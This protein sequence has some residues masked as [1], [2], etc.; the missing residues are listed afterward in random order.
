MQP[1][2]NLVSEFQR[3]HGAPPQKIARAP[4][5]VNLIGEHTDYNE[6]FVMPIA[7]DRD[8][9]IAARARDDNKICI[10][11]L[12]VGGGQ[13]DVFALDDIPHHPDYRWANY[14]RGVAYYLA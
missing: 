4:G 14:V 1:I 7:I 11:A 12:D 8:V 5:R 9:F 13:T 6:G 10:T 3:I 2:D